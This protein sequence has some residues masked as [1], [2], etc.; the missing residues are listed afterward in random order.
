MNIRSGSMG[1]EDRRPL[2]N[3]PAVD[4][5][6]QSSN[7]RLGAVL[8]ALYGFWGAR[9]AATTAGQ[10]AA[11]AR[12]DSYSVIMF[13]HT[14]SR[15]PIND[16]TSSP[17]DLLNAVLQFPADGGTNFELALTEAQAVMEQNWSNER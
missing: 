1:C 4:R 13:D 2:P 17:D 7:N 15:G 8:S 14:I 16:F 5:I 6:A 9:H 10:R 3:T 11:L 12:R